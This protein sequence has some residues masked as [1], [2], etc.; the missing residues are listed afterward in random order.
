MCGQL[1]FIFLL[2][3]VD[4]GGLDVSRHGEREFTLHTALVLNEAQTKVFYVGHLEDVDDMWSF[5]FILDEE[6]PHEFF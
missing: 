6:L 1:T 2:E 5:L 4:S 3:L